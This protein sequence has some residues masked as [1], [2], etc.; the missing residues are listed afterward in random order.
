MIG[1]KGKIVVVTDLTTQVTTEYVSMRQAAIALNTSLATVREY[2][3]N[4]KIKKKQI[5]ISN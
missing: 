4:Q 2:V 5:S 1:K 3:K